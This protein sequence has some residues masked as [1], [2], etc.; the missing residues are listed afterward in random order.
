MQLYVRDP[1]GNLLE[2]DWPDASTLDP[3]IVSGLS[4]LAD[5]VAQLP[6]SEGATLYHATAKR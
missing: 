5:D 2:I 3:T 1:G 4:R 6:E